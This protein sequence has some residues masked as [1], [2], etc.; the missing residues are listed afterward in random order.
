MCIY[1]KQGIVFEKMFV[2]DHCDVDL[3]MI[4]IKIKLPFTRDMFVLNAYQ[5]Q[6]PSGNLDRFIKET[7][8]TITLSRNNRVSELFIGGDIN[9]DMLH[10]NSINAKKIKKFIKINQFKQLVQKVT[11]SES[12]TCLDLI[13][14]DCDISKEHGTHIINT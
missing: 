2:L 12:N 10:P 1:I 3:E 7:Q 4:G 8:S 11:R 14:T 5:V 6:P 13:F 9:V